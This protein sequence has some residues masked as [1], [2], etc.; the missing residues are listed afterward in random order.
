M[1]TKS[2]YRMKTIHMTS[3]LNSFSYSSAKMD[4]QSPQATQQDLNNIGLPLRPQI[5]NDKRI[6][7]MSESTNGMDFRILLY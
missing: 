2:G 1:T 5:E 6:Y 4:N 7:S 3:I